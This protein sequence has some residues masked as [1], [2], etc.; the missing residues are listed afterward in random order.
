MAET[1]ARARGKTR[2]GHWQPSDGWPTNAIVVFA[3]VSKSGSTFTV[4]A[5]FSSAPKR[6]LEGSLASR[7]QSPTER[8]IDWLIEPF[9]RS[10]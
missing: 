9:E 6:Q 7:S 10:L 5:T 3:Q 4:V 8:P 2:L 1:S